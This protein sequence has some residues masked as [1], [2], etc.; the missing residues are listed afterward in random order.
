MQSLTHID[1]GVENN[2]KDL[3][4]KVGNHVRISKYKNIFEKVTF[5]TGLKFFL[6]KKV[7]NTVPWT[8]VISNLNNGEEIIKKKLQKTN[9]K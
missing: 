7:K 1:F 9:Q 4:F 8:R 6:L 2:N 5:Q 3:K